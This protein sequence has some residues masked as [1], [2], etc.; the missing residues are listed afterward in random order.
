MW[1]F[2]MQRGV[3]ATTDIDG[4]SRP[5]HERR[6]PHVDHQILGPLLA[7][8]LAARVFRLTSEPRTRDQRGDGVVAA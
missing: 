4:V 6:R 1:F 7:D 3:V 8:E 5:H 2:D